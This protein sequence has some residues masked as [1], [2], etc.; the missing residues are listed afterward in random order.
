[1]PP[2]AGRDK[3]EWRGC[4]PPFSFASMM[5]KRKCIILA[6]GSGA[7]IYLVTMAVSKQQ[8]PIYR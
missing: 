8:L 3:I 7:R 2:P 6:G 4:K 1:M 5:T